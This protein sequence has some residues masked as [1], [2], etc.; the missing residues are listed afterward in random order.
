MIVIPARIRH[1]RE[2]LAHRRSHGHF[3]GIRADGV[4]LVVSATFRPPGSSAS[5]STVA[6]A[7]VYASPR[8]TVEL[9]GVF[10]G[11]RYQLPV[12]IAERV[13]SAHSGQGN[14]CVPSVTRAPGSHAAQHHC[15]ARTT[16]KGA[17]APHVTS[18]G[19]Q[20]N[21]SWEYSAR[22]PARARSST[23]SRSPLSTSSPSSSRCGL[24][25][26]TWST[27]YPAIAAW[28]RMHQHRTRGLGCVAACGT[29]SHCDLV[30]RTPV[31][32]PRN[33]VRVRASVAS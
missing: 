19:V 29:G 32:A 12:N 26:T 25:Y 18:T 16:M 27:G 3:H 13:G 4:G 8:C 9:R 15:V 28:L 17:V 10:L 31:P 20:A 22:G 7:P 23:P 1:L 33:R 6:D 21:W 30:R 5:A 14:G 2:R 24:N 11:Y